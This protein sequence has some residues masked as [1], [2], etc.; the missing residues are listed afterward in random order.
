MT[1]GRKQ[2]PTLL[3][4]QW[5]F[6]IPHYIGT[7]YDG[8]AFVYHSRWGG[9]GI[10]KWQN[11]AVGDFNTNEGESRTAALHYFILVHLIKL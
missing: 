11:S 8:Q 6:Y 1:E 2:A 4:R 10:G 9:R 5:F 7:V 3:P